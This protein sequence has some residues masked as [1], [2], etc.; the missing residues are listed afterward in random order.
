MNAAYQRPPLVSRPH[1]RDTDRSLLRSRV[2]APLLE[3]GTP[4]SA[5]LCMGSAC[6]PSRVIDGCLL[7][8]SGLFGMGWGLAGVCPGPSFVTLGAGAT[9][10]GLAFVAAMTS[11]MLLHRW[12]T[13]GGPSMPGGGDV[14]GC[15]ATVVKR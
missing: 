15:P 3:P 14:C 10:M 5:A 4:M 2:A 7:L 9:P 8:G 11:G 1:P 13:A 6:A 12:T